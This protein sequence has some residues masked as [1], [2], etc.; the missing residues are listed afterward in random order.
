MSAIAKV[1]KESWVSWTYPDVPD[2]HGG[3]SDQPAWS[4]DGKWIY[5]TAK[6]GESVELN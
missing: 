6:V 5:Y 3:S 1:T 2:I 4:P